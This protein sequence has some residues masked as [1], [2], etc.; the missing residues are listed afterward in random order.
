[1][2][3]LRALILCLFALPITAQAQTPPQ[4][5]AITDGVALIPGGFPP[6]RQPDGNTVIFNAPKGLIVMD[7]GRHAWHRQ[8]I[9]NFA[10]AQDKPIAAVI[11]SHWHLD[12]T[13][14]N[15]A[16]R[17]AYPKVQVWGSLAIDGALRDFFPDSARQ[18]R[19]FLDSGQAPPDL[20]ED[21]RNDLATIDAP[22]HLR[23]DAV[24]TASGKQRIAGKA[25]HVN[26]ASNAATEG[27]VW[28]FDP[29]SGVAAAGDLV[30]LP[31]PFLDTACVKGWQDGLAA[32]WATPFT[33]VVPG[34]GAPMTRAQFAT[35][36]TAFDSF[37]DCARSTQ[38]KAR[39]AGDWAK[40]TETLGAPEAP[41]NART[42][43]MAEYYVDT[44]RSNGGNSKF[45]KAS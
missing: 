44:L 36:R 21:I 35:Y 24:V 40:A 22:A 37:I 4:P 17:R 34:H 5:R 16:I 14:G 26:L 18:G 38:D 2:T 25:F 33:V 43:A 1:M 15:A 27:D 3:G 9:L 28:V 20:A 23:P 45:C 29:K 12:H 8:A 10:T 31:V 6:N 39:C 13:S 32:I 30:T 7:T 11:N 19:A 41:D 42:I